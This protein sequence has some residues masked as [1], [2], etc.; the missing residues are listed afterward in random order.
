MSEHTDT[1]TESFDAADYDSVR[2]ALQAAPAGYGAERVID[3]FDP[4][5]EGGREGDA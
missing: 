2:D 4:V 1:D 5:I 3:Y